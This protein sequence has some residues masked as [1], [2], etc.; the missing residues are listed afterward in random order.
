MIKNFNQLSSLDPYILHYTKDTLLENIF[1]YS[2]FSVIDLFD[3]FASICYCDFYNH[4][5]EDKYNIIE[6]NVGVTQPER[7]NLI[8]SDLENLISFM[9]NGEVW[10]INFYKKEKEKLNINNMQIGLKKDINSIALLS[11]GLD[12]L[13]GATQ[14]LNNNTLFVTFMTNK[15]EANKAK[16]SFDVILKSNPNCY[17]VRIHKLQFKMP[18]QS[19]QRTRSLLFIGSALL[20]A[21]YYNVKSIKI[22]ENGIM[23]LNPTFSFRRRVTHTTHPRTLFMINSILKRLSININVV[24]P[25]N[26]MT[27]TEVINLI[28]NEWNGLISNTKTC[29]KMPGSK[30]FQNRKKSG[31]C[32]CG[33]CTACLLRQIS[34]V[35]SFKKEC[36]DEYIL[37]VNISSLNEI[38]KY[39]YLHGNNP[40]K[41]NT[42]SYYKFVEKQSLLQYYNEFKDKIYTG[43]I[44]KYLELSPLLF[45]DEYKQKY[46]AMLLKFAEEIQNYINIQK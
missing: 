39:E 11:G 41:V 44:F 16:Q 43:D 42:I 18:K 40:T 22:Y 15:T 45:K 25:F 38:Q 26:F 2:N 27:K 32:Q 5:N 10:Q 24:N 13:A 7:F 17:H 14:E 37:P 20:Y 3:T 28:P 1:D 9:T 6:L 12:A 36:D 33:I 34:I 23:S 8:K 30:P 31:I 46:N 4:R 35:N 29:S 21:D 19:T